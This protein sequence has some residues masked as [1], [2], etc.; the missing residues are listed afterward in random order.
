MKLQELQLIISGLSGAKATAVS[1]LLWVLVLL[2]GW[3]PGVRNQSL[4]F[5]IEFSNKVRELVGRTTSRIANECTRQRIAISLGTI[6]LVHVFVKVALPSMSDTF[7]DK[8]SEVIH[9]TKAEPVYTPKR[10]RQCF[11]QSALPPT[12]ERPGHTHPTSAALRASATRFIDNLALALGFP[13]FIMQ[14]SS[15]DVAAGYVGNRQFYFGKDLDKEPDRR[16]KKEIEALVLVDTDEYIDMDALL[17]YQRAPVF[18]YTFQPSKVADSTGEYAFTFDKNNQVSYQVSGGALYQ[19]PV[20][21]W[22][23]DHVTAYKTLFGV[24]TSATTYLVETKPVDEHHSIVMLAPVGTWSF[25]WSVLTHFIESNTVKRLAPNANEYNVLHVK[26]SGDLLTSVG[27]PGSHLSATVSKADMD[28]CLTVADSRGALSVHTANT[29]LKSSLSEAYL[30]AAY[31]NSQRQGGTFYVDRS[32][33]LRKYQPHTTSYDHEAVPMMEPYMNPLVPGGAY[34]P[35]TSDATVHRSIEGRITEN[36]KQAPEISNFIMD[37]VKQFAEELIPAEMVHTVLPTDFEEVCERQSKPRQRAIL[38]EAQ[39]RPYTTDA[40]SFLKKEVYQK[41]SDPRLITTFDGTIKLEMSTYAYSVAEALKTLSSL[42]ETPFYTSGMS[43]KDVA[44]AVADIC[45][46]NQTRYLYLGDFERMDKSIQEAARAVVRCVILR[47]VHID[48]HNHV[49]EMLDM[50]FGDILV[51]TTSGYSYYLG[52]KQGSGAPLT[53]LAQTL[54][55]MFSAFVGFR[56]MPSTE[57]NTRYMLPTEAMYMTLQG[58]YCGDD[59]AIPNLPIKAHAKA[60]AMIGLVVKAELAHP[61]GSGAQVNFLSRFYSTEVWRGNPNSTCDILRTLTK[62]HVTRRHPAPPIVKMVEKARAYA[63]SDANTPFIGPFVTKI[64]ALAIDMPETNFLE[65]W[66][67]EFTDDHYPNEYCD[68]HEIVEHKLCNELGFEPGPFEAWLNVVNDLEDFLNI[69]C[70][71]DTLPLRQGKVDM[72]INDEIVVEG[73]TKG[74]QD[75]PA[76]PAII[77]SPD[78]VALTRNQRRKKAQAAKR[79][80]TKV[81][82]GGKKPRPAAKPKQRG[83][84]HQGPKQKGSEPKARAQK[85]KA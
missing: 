3:V 23:S 65:I 16:S 31:A 25:P 67:A 57:L 38:E 1:R 69:P 52:T 34:V 83:A 4:Q 39:N 58:I 42:S 75:V 54:V 30:V 84:K 37:C 12:A 15:R 20:Y 60:C 71:V 70:F 24:R 85:A 62:F 63:Y 47:L 14:Q 27:T 48:H 44:Q 41:P 80:I 73:E 43:P 22:S 36:V 59:S 32:E 26:T 49:N 33:P 51:K 11:S 2:K 66:N 40:K 28:T 5:I 50:F 6:S 17:A 72:V 82:T 35:D 53:A 21:D 56:T 68:A 78:E 9:A 81:A 46:A 55:N 74:I 19:H 18:L 13:I 79:L 10:L 29:I 76:P 77:S 45:S 7:R 64:T 8:L 61:D